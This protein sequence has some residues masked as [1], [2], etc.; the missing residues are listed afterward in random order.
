M[1]QNA[2]NSPTTYLSHLNVHDFCD[3]HILHSFIL[4]S[5]SDLLLA[6]FTYAVEYIIFE[7]EN[8]EIQMLP[9]DL[10]TFHYFNPNILEKLMQGI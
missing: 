9:F 4:H 1:Y 2:T 7:N 10:H 6:T 8:G 3:Y 5:F